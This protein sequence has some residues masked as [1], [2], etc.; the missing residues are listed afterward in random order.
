[1]NR[2]ELNNNGYWEIPDGIDTTDF[3]FTWR[4]DPLERPFIHQFGTQ[5]QKTNGPKFIVPGAEGIKYQD[6]TWA[7]RLPNDENFVYLIDNVSMDTTWH[8]DDTDPPYIY[9]FGNQWHSA[10]IMPTVE[11]RMPGA[12]VR[13]YI[14]DISAILKPTRENWKILHDHIMFDYSWVPDPNDPPYNYVFGNQWYDANVMPT[15]VYK[16]KGAIETKY[17][18]DV[19]ATLLPNYDNYELLIDRKIDFDYSWVPDP[20]DPPSYTYIFGNQWYSAED[21]PT[22][23]YKINNSSI[24]KYIENI[25]ARVLDDFGVWNIPFD[26]D[27]TE[28]DY[29]WLPRSG[30]PKM[31]Q[32]GT[33]WQKTGGPVLIVRG[34]TSVI[35]KDVMKVTK[36]PSSKNYTKLYDSEFD[37]SWHPDATEPPY[38]YVF[39]N[40]WYD[41][42]TMPTVLYT[43]PGATE[44]KY[45]DTIKATLI[46]NKDNYT[47]LIDLE[48]DF[49][50]SW[51]PDPNDPPYIYV[52]GNQWYDSLTMPTL[53]YTV[54]GATDKKYIDDI[55]C[56]LN[57]NKKRWFIPND[58]E[59]FDYSWLPHPDEPNVNW[60][61]G[62]QWQKT[63]GPIYIGIRTNEF[64]FTDILTATK[65]P[66]HTNYTKLIEN[67]DFDYSW[68]PDSNAPPYIYVFGNQW[69]DSITMPTLMYTVPGAT[70]KKYINDI[71]CTLTPNHDAWYIPD[72]LEDFDYS[73]IP[74]P[75]EPPMNWQF[76][77]QWQKTGGPRY[78]N[79]KSAEIKFTD[80]MRATKKSEIIRNYRQMVSNI[81]FDYSWHPDENEPPYNYVFGNQWYDAETMPTLV[82]RVKGATEKKY[83]NEVKATL[84]PDKT[85]YKSLIDLEFDFDY[86]WRPDPND[87][88]FNYVFGNQWYDSIAMPTLM[89]CVPKATQTKYIDSI[90]CILKSDCS[91]WI[92]PEDIENYFDYSWT[93]NPKD[94]LY[95]Y[96]FSTQ[97]QKTGGPRYVMPG[98]TAI[99]Y[100]DT[101]RAIKKSVKNRNYRALVNN[102]DFDYSWHPD[103]NDP[104]F[105]YVFGNQWY[106]AEIM[107]TLVYRVKGAT[108]KKY[109]HTLSATLLDDKTNW[110]V[111]D[112][113]EGGF[114]YSWRPNPHDPAFIYQFPTQHQRTGGPK[115]IVEGAT[116]IKY[117]DS[118]RATKLPNMRNWRIIEPIL[119]TTFDFSWH[120]D[121]SEGDYSYVFGNKFHKPEIMPTLVYKGKLGNKYNYDMTPDLDIQYISYTDSIFDAL[122][123][124]EVKTAYAYV[125]NFEQ[126]TLDN[127]LGYTQLKQEKPTI[128]LIGDN[129]AIVPRDA[130]VYLYD[131]LNDY[132]HVLQHNSDIKMP[133]LDIIFISNGE[134]CAHENYQHLKQITKNLPNRVKII[135]NVNGRVASQ[136]AA[137]NASKTP[138]YF[139]I[140]AK[141]KVSEDFDFSWQPNRFKSSR[142]YIF[143]ATNEMNG[144]EYGHMAIV[145]NNKKLTLNT[146]VR[147][148]DFTMDSPT[149]VVDINS[150]IATYNSGAWDTWRTS[151]RECIKLNYAKDKK[152]KERL[153]TWMTIATGEFA[154]YS[155]LGA[156][157]A[158]EYYKS[159]NGKLQ[160]LLL[161]YDWEWLITQ[162]TRL[163]INKDIK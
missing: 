29:S 69:Y 56:M 158:T 144:L 148:L 156:Q 41:S 100:S 71:K 77:T 42:K 66:T 34:G 67:I 23:A 113:I 62:T 87:P 59:D 133:P 27:D 11:Y 91:N 129:S 68:H 134:E 83:I 138:W 151:F 128:H 78:L 162:Y 15:V 64:K 21:M 85:N 40:Q 61:F 50:Y 105:N 88:P 48:F 159:V 103:E 130:I 160:D 107:P 86:S 75:D 122:I 10:E 96:Q 89:Y 6:S 112:D 154:E 90:K 114:D 1:M 57:P 80:I 97:W 72:N 98:A 43:T 28:F 12:T 52:F 161:S 20:N 8:P 136:H 143:R 30:M 82:Y 141:L 139:L 53:M 131:K 31:Y 149:E 150:G 39:G 51:R 33:Q 93:P 94:G 132:D 44:K 153:Q 74:H 35:Y 36:T 37:Y 101:Q 123:E 2:I 145:A 5:H 127:G 81:E 73:W 146:V 13:K 9:V 17:I 126:T 157:Q 24:F 155:I 109:V 26:I 108:E 45:I 63:G 147:G 58:I 38:I 140:N 55:K 142:H 22:V 116:D 102:I 111:P 120:P 115:Y 99:K 14:N 125:A 19:K 163:V 118:Q 84:L 18:T 104:P 124:T 32:F 54:S 121:E 70:E 110:I 152:S 16:V 106:D 3:D 25:K 46:E 117:I 119:T 4:P 60:Q 49:D 135:S 95:V 76:G 65:K 79:T 92:I 137:A 7:K 47:T